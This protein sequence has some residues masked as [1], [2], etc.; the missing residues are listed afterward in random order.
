MD[1]TKLYPEFSWPEDFKRL[2]ARNPERIGYWYMLT[3]RQFN[4]WIEGI[5]E[6]YPHRKLIPFAVKCYND[7]VAC[8]E[9]GKGETIQVVHDFGAPGREQ[10]ESY[11]NLQEWMQE[12]VSNEEW[13]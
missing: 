10:R 5:R 1:P 12:A 2:L 13:L 11:A 9:I 8:Y 6:R 3:E 7:D 4:T